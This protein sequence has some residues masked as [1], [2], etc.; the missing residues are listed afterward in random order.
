[1]N[2]LT[3]D[4]HAN[5]TCR[6][7]QL[8]KAA[9]PAGEVEFDGQAM[10][11]ELAE[12]PPAVEYVPA[13]QSEHAADPVDVL[14]FPATHAAHGPP[15]GPVDPVLQVQFVK[16]ALPAVELELVGQA[17]HDPSVVCPVSILQNEPGTR[18]RNGAHHHRSRQ[19]P[20]SPFL[21]HDIHARTKIYMR[22]QI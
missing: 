6:G 1:M 4:R 18:V 10:H 21:I 14:Y 12:D 9:L 2:H 19:I 17:V 5:T 15:F 8:V 7:E 11:V 16:A 3:L 13:S 22:T 20:C